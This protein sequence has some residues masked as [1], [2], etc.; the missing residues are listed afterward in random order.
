MDALHCLNEIVK[1]FIFRETVIYPLQF[2]DVVEKV[3]MG[4]KLL[5]QVNFV[6]VLKVIEQS[7]YV[8]VLQQRVHLNLSIHCLS[9]LS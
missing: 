3:V 7:D 4:S 2:T 6:L 8:L 1:G 5:Q 9:E